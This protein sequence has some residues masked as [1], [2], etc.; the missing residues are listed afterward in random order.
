MIEINGSLVLSYTNCKR[1][2][3]LMS[4]RMIPEQD[5]TL[6]TLG[7]ILHE[8]SYDYHGE[9]DIQIENIKLDLVE[10]KRGKTIV[11]EIKKSRYSLDGA[12]YQLLYYL[13]RLKQLGIEAE[14]QLL[15]PVEKKKIEISLDT[16]SEEKIKNICEEIQQIV[17]GQIPE[18]DRNQTSCKSCAYYTYCW[19]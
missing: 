19:V 12:K 17:D 8:N 14:G 11:S 6:M 7:R 3:W 1:E 16:E 18:I 5:G 4:R 15:V 9:K 2:A 10:E 13:Y